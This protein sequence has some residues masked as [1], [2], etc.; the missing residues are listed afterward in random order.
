MFL[1]LLGSME[2]E[3]MMST[4]K[5]EK[6]KTGCF[7]MGKSGNRMVIE[8]DSGTLIYANLYGDE[9][10]RR[11]FREEVMP[12]TVSDFQ[13]HIVHISDDM[14]ECYG[15]IYHSGQLL[16]CKAHC[17]FFCMVI[18]M[19]NELG[20]W[21]LCHTLFRDMEMSNSEAVS[22]GLFRVETAAFNVFLGTEEYLEKRVM[23]CMLCDM[24]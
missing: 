3:V 5:E 7:A 4:K 1:W 21:G 18:G 19:V 10:L 15:R 13:M 6:V 24:V 2:V 16:H 22:R 9:D 11:K 12:Q 20:P 17:N 23:D 14:K 8:F